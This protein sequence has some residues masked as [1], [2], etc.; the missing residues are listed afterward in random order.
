LTDLAEGQATIAHDDTLADDAIV[1][2]FS[3]TPEQPDRTMV[4]IPG[5]FD[6]SDL[7]SHLPWSARPTGTLA[8]VGAYQRKMDRIVAVRDGSLL[9]HDADRGRRRRGRRR[10]P[11]DPHRLPEPPAS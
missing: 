8:N 3:A 4:A 1:A 11:V 2:A 9:R 5:R 10:A 6:H 7:V